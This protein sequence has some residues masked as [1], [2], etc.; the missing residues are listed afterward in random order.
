M[1]IKT[2]KQVVEQLGGVGPNNLTQV[3][4]SMLTEAFHTLNDNVNHGWVTPGWGVKISDEPNHSWVNPNNVL[5]ELKWTPVVNDPNLD[6]E[7]M[8]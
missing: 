6:A 7:N 2:A 5:P 4:S 8:G 3:E 1:D